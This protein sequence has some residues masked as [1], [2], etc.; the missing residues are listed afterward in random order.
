MYCIGGGMVKGRIE[1]YGLYSTASKVFGGPINN[2]IYAR[3]ICR[4]RKL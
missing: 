1:D 2:I 4:G 3:A